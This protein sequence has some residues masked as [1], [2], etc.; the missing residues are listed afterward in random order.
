MPRRRRTSSLGYLA[1]IVIAILLLLW[2]S[3]ILRVQVSPQVN[4]PPEVQTP[5][6]QLPEVV[7]TPLAQVPQVLGTL[8][9]TPQVLGT[10]AA[11]PSVSAPTL[12]G[13]RTKTSGCVS[14]NA[15]PDSACTPGATLNVAKDQICQPGYSTSVRDV[16][17]SEK[18]QVYAEYG[19]TQHSAGE[20]EVDHLVSL[21]LGGSNDIANLWPEPAEPKPGFHEKD[22]VENYLHAQVCSGAI[23][24]QQAQTQIASNWMTVYQEMPTK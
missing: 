14:H 21:E 6:A 20:Y 3:G 12:L 4:V 22:K 11:A 19:I 15:L 7:G 13:Q 24:L 1:L 17:E 2:V 5:A 10:R 18:N 16:P 23:S 9:A 8:A